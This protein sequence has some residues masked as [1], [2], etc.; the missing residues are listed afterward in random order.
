MCRFVLYMGP[1]IKMGSLVT[2]PTHSIIVQSYRSEEREEPLNGDGFGVAWYPT[3]TDDAPAVFKSVSPAWN[4]QNLLNLSRVIHSHCIL[5]HVRAASPGLPVTRLNCHPFAWERFAFMH[6]GR[7]GGF[8]TVKRQL[9]GMLTDSSY[10]W[11]Q[12]TTDSE[13]IFALFVD[14]YC[15]LEGE[16]PAEK[17][18]TAL[19][20]TIKSVEVLCQSAGH[21]AGCDLN[22]AVTD[23]RSAVVSRYSTDGST[24]NSLYVHTGH[25]YSCDGGDAK[26]SPS[27]DPT[28]LVASEPLTLDASWHSVDANHIVVINESLEV[29]IRPLDIH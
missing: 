12:G 16:A 26:L 8:Q 28:V 21:T 14:S 6:N 4:N 3:D 25:R 23:G 17:M 7:I 13:T 19:V 5:A 10:A 1:E 29:D 24:P 2:Q 11:V 20:A 22:L 27:A 15:A 9:H 18:A